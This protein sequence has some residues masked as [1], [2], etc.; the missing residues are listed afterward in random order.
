MSSDPYLP[1]GCTNRDIDGPKAAQ[2]G[3][4]A[5]YDSRFRHDNPYLYGTTEYGDWDDGWLGAKEEYEEGYK[6]A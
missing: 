1:P 4:D 6:D 3:C 2:E 5:F